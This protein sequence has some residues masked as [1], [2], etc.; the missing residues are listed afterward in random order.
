MINYS[1]PKIES[2]TVNSFGQV[3]NKKPSDY[4]LP[5]EKKKEEKKQDIKESKSIKT[6]L[7]TPDEARKTK[8]L[9]AI[10]LSIAGATVLTA[11]TVFFILKGGPQG[12]TK[13]F[14]KW[15]D[16]LERKLQNDILEN[17]G[18]TSAKNKVYLFGLKAVDSAMQRTEAINN[19]T[20]IKDILFKRM[21][22]FCK[23]LRKVHDDITE[24]FEK[25]GRKSVVTTYRNTKNQF[26]D[27]VNLSSNI[28]RQA[29]MQDPAKP[30][31]IN[32]VTLQKSQWLQRVEELNDEL[33]VDY[34]L[35]FGKRGQRSRYVIYKKVAE[36]LKTVFAKLDTFWSK[37]L[38]SKFMAES[39]IIKEKQAIQAQTLDYRRDIAFSKNDL[40][41]DADNL[42]MKISGLFPFKDSDKLT[43][44][45][46]LRSSLKKGIKA[47]DFEE[48]IRPK[49]Q[50]Q[51]SE[52]RSSLNSSV[53][54]GIPTEQVTKLFEQID[55]LSNL[56][57]NFKPGK[58]DQIL[59]IYKHI[60][61]KKDYKHIENS[62]ASSVKSL[63]K[64]IRLETE[65]F[66]SKL[67]DLVLGSAPTDILS[68]LGGLGVLGYQLGKS[69]DNEQRTSISLKYGIP[70]LA[71]IGVSLYCNAKLYAGTKSLLIGTL[72]SL[73]LNKIGVW[74]DDSLKNYK[75]QQKSKK[76]QANIL[77][78]GNKTVSPQVSI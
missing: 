78:E 41:K 68:M 31:Q 37:D 24:L 10:G 65:E 51:L 17:K 57:D 15:R 20:T 49:L 32:G 35:R 36:R 22:G 47:P 76:S 75:Q 3:S 1:I 25:I 48:K 72:S 30:I 18:L 44:L 39:A 16:Y 34:Y 46:N 63:D 28:T 54:T 43:M 11:G 77:P 52:L 69:E 5:I 29:L 71:G 53:D 64:S 73:A 60:L 33:L 14:L 2:K 67:R 40:F 66:V 9:K 58:I 61:S 12:L 21:M 55:N 7:I 23:P 13:T 38:Y 27:S 6:I 56:I 50:Q 70:A 59:E 42:I 4:W 45:I 8:N 19:F 26:S 62:Y 74:A